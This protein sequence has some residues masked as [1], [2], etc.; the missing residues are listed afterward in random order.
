MKVISHL[1]RIETSPIWIDREEVLLLLLMAISSISAT[2][3]MLPL[4]NSSLSSKSNSPFLSFSP[5]NAQKTH[6]QPLKSPFSS[7]SSNSQG[8]FRVFAAPELLDSD[9][10]T[11][12]SVASESLD[13]APDSVVLEVGVKISCSIL[14]I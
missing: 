13:V 12:E 3:P 10:T 8:H 2:L 1:H 11:T 7:I 4:R 14:W 5:S 6:H 9:Q